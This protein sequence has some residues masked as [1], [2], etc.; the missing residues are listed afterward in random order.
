MRRLRADALGLAGDAAC[1]IASVTNVEETTPAE[2]RRIGR[3]GAKGVVR[4]R[5][6]DA[7]Q[8]ASRREA[9]RRVALDLK[10]ASGREEAVGIV[11]V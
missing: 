10:G 3:L 11:L 1:C 9:R 5:L 4:A 7:A 2:R 6:D 8:R